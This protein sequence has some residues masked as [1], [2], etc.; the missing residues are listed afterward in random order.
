MNANVT[1]ALMAVLIVMNLLLFVQV[2]RLKSGTGPALVDISSYIGRPELPDVAIADRD[3]NTVKL[4]ALVA[5]DEPTLMVFFS[6]SDCPNCF[7]EKSL[8]SQVSAETAAHVVGIAVSASAHEF[9]RWVSHMD[10][11]IPIY[12]DT[13][14]SVF[15]SMRFRVTPLKELIREGGDLVW[16]YPPRL[17]EPEQ[18][19]FWRDFRHAIEI[20]F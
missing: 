3:G 5:E 10:F 8:W 4:R 19:S 11:S 7:S 18:A 1:K 2:Y 16:A 13:T 15:D 9:W 17:S 20:H 6:S 12:L 14:F